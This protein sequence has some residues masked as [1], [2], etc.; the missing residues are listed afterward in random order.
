MKK[1]QDF[2]PNKIGKSKLKNS[3]AKDYGLKKRLWMLIPIVMLAAAATGAW[4]ILKPT[5]AKSQ[6]VVCSG[7]QAEQ[8]ACWQQRYNAMIQQQ[9]PEAAF[10][11]FKKAYNDNPY[12]KSNCHQIGH[13][14]GRAAAKKYDTLVK[15]YEHGDNFCW[16]GYYHGAIETI[17]QAIGQEKILAQINTVCA[18]FL[19][20][21]PYSFDHYN[22]VHGMGH[23]LMA[24][25]NNELFTVLATC[26]AFEGDWQQ[27]SCYSGAFM[28]NIMKEINPGEHTN[29]LNADDPLYPCTAVSDRYKEQC[30]LMQTSHALI[31]VGN[32][33]NKVFGLCASVGPP[34]DKTC[35]Q[36]LGR[37]VSGGSSSDTARTLELCM[38][39]AASE[40]RDN[41]FTGAVKDFISYYHSDQ[42]GL[43]LCQAIPD[44]QLAA[45]CTNV[46][47]D[48]YKTF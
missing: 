33:Y 2:L 12:V 41:C 36:S 10:T 37:D 45:N 44:P 22:C 26:D 5:L 43:A 38:M 6:I 23:G 8:F 40:A 20:A 42:Q 31:V 24:I 39:G 1:R 9:S 48:Y 34:Y 46:A 11:D 47:H 25:Q 14:I 13:V 19:K 30:Y 29:Y 21:R 35:Y 28:E 17:A 16:S 27:Q 18:D 32:D 7:Q 3:K 4:V 15:T